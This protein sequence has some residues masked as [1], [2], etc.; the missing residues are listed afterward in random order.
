MSHVW[1]WNAHRTE[2]IFVVRSAATFELDGTQR[3][4]QHE[5]G[6]LV[7][8]KNAKTLNTT[9]S[10]GQQSYKSRSQ[11]Q[12]VVAEARFEDKMECSPFSFQSP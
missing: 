6:K 4:Y 7:I 10:P 9:K 2:G 1:Q 8:K 5:E 11:V 3:E 12:Y